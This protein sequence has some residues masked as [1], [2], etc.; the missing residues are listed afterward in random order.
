MEIVTTLFAFDGVKVREVSAAEVN[1]KLM[2]FVKKIEEEEEED[3]EAND[4][5]GIDVPPMAGKRAR[6]FT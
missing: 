3:G 6:H 1:D 2:K 4:F 5:G